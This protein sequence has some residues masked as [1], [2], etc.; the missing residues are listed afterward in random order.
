[1]LTIIQKKQSAMPRAEH[2]QLH[3]QQEIPTIELTIADHKL[4]QWQWQ[5][6]NVHIAHSRLQTVAV[7][8][9]Y[10]KVLQ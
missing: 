7:T 1:M 10:H 2:K 6:A 9:A 5:I 4:L 8:R 3:C